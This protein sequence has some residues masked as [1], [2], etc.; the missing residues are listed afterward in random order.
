MN[1]TVTIITIN[2]NNA[3]G[4]K[5]TMDSVVAQ[6]YSQIDY[7]VIDGASNDGS[8]EVIKNFDQ[9]KNLRWFSEE[10]KGI[11]NA[12][13]KGIQKATGTYV[14]FLNSG[15]YLDTEKVIADIFSI[16]YT[17]DILYGLI[18]T[19]DQNNKTIKNYP[20]QLSLD[21]L[22]SSSLPHP[23][24]F[25]RKALFDKL[26]GY[27]ESLKIVG[28]WA[29]NLSA[30]AAN[31]ATTQPLKKVVSVFDMTGI[32]SQIKQQEL[33]KAEGEKVLKKIFGSVIAAYIIES[34]EKKRELS[35]LK[36]IKK[37][38]FSR[39]FKKLFDND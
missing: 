12:M 25:Y 17:K 9:N 6:T 38:S 37:P 1:T 3:A 31:R 20:D 7:I 10:D 5:K 28:D 27:D 21:F 32:S 4:L 36:K 35:A 19:K 8:I 15:D 2:Y 29:F 26:G 33:K 11:Y 39:Y 16:S 23:A 30:I 14:L 24:T 22:L 34:Q 13:N 18:K